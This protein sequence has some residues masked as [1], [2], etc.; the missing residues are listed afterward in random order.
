[1]PELVALPD[2]AVLAMYTDGLIERPRLNMD[3]AIDLFAGV[4]GRGPDARPA[5]LVS[6]VAERLG[7]PDDDVALLVVSFEAERTRFDA[8]LRADPSVLAGMRRRLRA[9]LLRRGYSGD[10]GSKILLAVSEACNNS[11]GTHTTGDS[12]L[13][14]S[15]PT[16]VQAGSRSSWRTAEPGAPSSRARNVAVACS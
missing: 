11:V 6:R 12:A 13:C 4:L 7:E 5:E 14:A 10:E 1:V 9:W 15:A 2:R 8:E 16:T 3:D